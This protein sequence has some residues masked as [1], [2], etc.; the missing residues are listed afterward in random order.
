MFET[1]RIKKILANFG[2]AQNARNQEL[3]DQLEKFG[4]L[5]VPL[6]ADE[7]RYNRMKYSDAEKIFHRLF[8]IKDI[9]VFIKGLGE[10]KENIRELYKETIIRFGRSGAALALIEH[11]GDSDNMIRKMAADIIIEISDASVAPRIIP[12]IRHESKDVKKTAMDILSA[13]KAEKASDA[14]IPLL[15][16]SDSWI[17]RKAIEALCRLKNRDVLPRLLALALE[18]GDPK[19]A[20]PALELASEIG[21]PEHTSAA[22]QMIKSSDLVIRQKATEAVILMADSTIVPEVMLFLK[23]D[24]VNV[25]RAATDILNGLKDTKTASALVKA[26][27]D[28]DW[29]VRE[30]ATDALSELGGGKVSEMIK[31]LLFDKDESVRRCA[32]EFYCRV[33]DPSAL[34]ALVKLLE[35]ED[36]WVREKAITALGFIGDPVAIE[37]ISKLLGDKEVKWAIPKA[38]ASIGHKSALKALSKLAKDDKTQVRMETLKAVGGLGGDEA[39]ALVKTMALDSEPRIQEEALLILRSLTGRIW[40]LDEVMEEIKAEDDKTGGDEPEEAKAGDRLT[41]AILVVDLCKST[42]VASHYG[43]SALYELMKE[44][45]K[46]VTPLAR[47]AGIRF[48]KSTGDGFLMTFDSTLKATWMAVETLEKLAS[49]NANIEEKRR[50]NVRFAINVGETRVNTSGDRVGNAVNMAFRLEGAKKEDITASHEG[51]KPDEMLEQNRILI[52]EAVKCEL[53]DKPKPEWCFLG[54]FELKGMTGLHRIYQLIA[55]KP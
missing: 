4:V 47:E 25:R 24:D 39:V 2:A 16:D 18:E 43:D 1:S 26:M 32:V 10:S 45:D 54:F 53:E 34:E 27:K 33:K 31:E 40:L 38:L 3:I 52:T 6:V 15:D 46:I 35:D 23:D 22:L 13:I 49:R 37:P 30:I 55:E 44:L 19:V 20:R 48:M 42:D 9:N 36:W 5:P 8:D 51:A 41:E 50:M 28:A 14:I 12:F 21:G 17:R 7:L 29:W 11:L